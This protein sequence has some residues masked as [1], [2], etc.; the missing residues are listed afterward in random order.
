MRAP[1]KATCRESLEA[2]TTITSPARKIQLPAEGRSGVACWVHMASG[3]CIRTTLL[4]LHSTLACLCFTMD[5][6][7]I[8][9]RASRM[10]SGCDTTTPRALWKDSIYFQSKERDLNADGAK[11]RF[12]RIRNHTPQLTCP[13]S[14]LHISGMESICFHMSPPFEKACKLSH[15]ILGLNTPQL[16]LTGVWRNGSASDSRSEG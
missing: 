12:F 3:P 11:S 1:R 15:F 10:L 2:S 16:R 7:G 5:T 6:L 9:P 8:E 4:T 14:I 13:K